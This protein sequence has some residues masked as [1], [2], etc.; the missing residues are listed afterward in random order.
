M[1]MDYKK[2]YEEWLT[3][4]FFDEA[5]RQEL[6]AIKDDEREIKERFY[7][8]LEFGTA[9]LRGI[10]GAGTNRMIIILLQRQHR[11]LQIIS[12]SVSSRRRVLR[13]HMIPDTVHQSLQM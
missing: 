3:N 4:P 13:L 2:V 12:N 1:D 6:A 7:M 10:I 5:T 9:G 11:D 8:D